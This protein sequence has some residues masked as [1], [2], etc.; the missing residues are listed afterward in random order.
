MNNSKRPKFLDRIEPWHSLYDI[1]AKAQP[2]KP[3]KPQTQSVTD[4]PPQ[5]HPSSGIKLNQEQVAFGMDLIAN[6]F[7]ENSIR[8]HRL[9]FSSR[10]FEYHRRWFE[11]KKTIWTFPLGH[12][13]FLVKK[14]G[15]YRLF[16][17]DVEKELDQHS[18]ALNLA[19]HHLRRDPEIT[20]IQKQVKVRDNAIV[21]LLLHLK[22]GQREAW[23]VTLSIGNVVS[24]CSRLSG[25]GFSTIVF[26]CRDHTIRQ[27]AWN[28]L[29][30]AGLPEG[31]FA[32]V[33]CVLFSALL[34]KY[35]TV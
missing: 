28:M 7:D 12:Y 3:A 21:D 24:N 11:T 27:G 18:F 8:R 10:K 1:P 34:K 15:L 30:A 25:C 6:P 17:I 4:L 33:R 9:G 13:R 31:L 2:A 32:K 19:C 20:Q 35:K 26:L 23:E 29:K 22:N 5:T 16:N 14:E